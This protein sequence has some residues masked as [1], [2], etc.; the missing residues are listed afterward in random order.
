MN[1]KPV[2]YIVVYPHSFPVHSVFRASFQGTALSGHREGPAFIQLIQVHDLFAVCADGVFLSRQDKHG[3]T[4]RNPSKPVGRV[5]VLKSSKHVI[6]KT[7]GGNCT[8]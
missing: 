1:D 7:D 8:A 6:I 5:K 3:R 4:G 2:Q